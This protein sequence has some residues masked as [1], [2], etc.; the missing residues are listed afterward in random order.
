[1]NHNPQNLNQ[2][3]NNPYALSINRPIVAEDDDDTDFDDFGS[4]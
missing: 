2:L 4:L 1:M 3:N